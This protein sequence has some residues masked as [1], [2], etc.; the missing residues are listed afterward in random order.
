M[1]DD[2]QHQV[3]NTRAIIIQIHFNHI[4][5]VSDV[6]HILAFAK[7]IIFVCKA[8]KQGQ[9]KISFFHDHCKKNYL[10]TKM[11]EI[12]ITCDE[13]TSLYPIGL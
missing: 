6:M 7:K 5:I 4:T 12:T 2:Q 10:L 9:N 8:T 13:K 1:G 11:G 3:V